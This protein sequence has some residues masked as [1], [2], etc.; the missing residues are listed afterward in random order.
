MKYY[1]SCFVIDVEIGETDIVLTDSQRNRYFLT[2]ARQ[3]NARFK[4]WF[5]KFLRGIAQTP[6]TFEYEIQGEGADFE[7][8]IVRFFSCGQAEQ[9]I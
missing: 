4:A 7:M 5:I 8:R 1:R 9:N 3:K 2:R 6:T